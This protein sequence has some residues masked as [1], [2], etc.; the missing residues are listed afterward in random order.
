MANENNST[1]KKEVTI[2]DIVYYFTIKYKGD[3]ESIYN[4]LNVKEEI[5]NDEFL[6]IYNEK[7]EGYI[8]LL[9][10]IYP[11]N[12]KE[13]YKP[14]FSLFVAGNWKLLEEMKTKKT[15][16]V[17]NLTQDELKDFKKTFEGLKDDF[18][19]CV[20]SHDRELI[21]YL[22]K[23]DYTFILV[24]EANVEKT[25]K[26]FDITEGDIHKNKCLILTETPLNNDKILGLDNSFARV[27]F[28]LTGNAYIGSDNRKE[29]LAKINE[30]LEID[31]LDSVPFKD[32]VHAV[33]DKSYD[34]EKVVDNRSK[35][36]EKS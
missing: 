26:S 14:P 18:F 23:N 4:A 35:G 15:M 22:N 2:N 1:T 5:D 19:F 29:Y 7:K 17:T 6:K 32:F 28:G 12:L 20:T 36:L 16:S 10:K 30:Y 24:S 25:K 13:F 9:D 34:D 11:D 3:W 33:N 8:N 27:W 21:D 31:E